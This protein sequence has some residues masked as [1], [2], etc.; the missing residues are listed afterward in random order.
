MKIYYQQKMT[1]SG[2]GYRTTLSGPYLYAFWREGKKM[3]SAY[4]GKFTEEEFLRQDTDA[5]RVSAKKLPIQLGPQTRVTRDLDG[6][7][8][9]EEFVREIELP[10]IGPHVAIATADDVL[11]SLGCH[12]TMSREQVRKAVFNANARRSECD[13]SRAARMAAFDMLIALKKWKKRQQ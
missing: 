5:T 4:L 1:R 3:R 13:A 2:H 11:A 8:F 10:E 6:Q 9:L 7:T 12:A